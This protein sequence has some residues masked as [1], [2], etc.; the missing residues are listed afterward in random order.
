MDP[1]GTIKWTRVL[2]SMAG[3]MKYQRNK[4]N[5]NWALRIRSL[6]PKREIPFHYKGKIPHTALPQG[7]PNAIGKDTCC[8]H[9]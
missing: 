5:V 8:H 9:M 4:C 7:K 6:T 2:I 3:V 1:R